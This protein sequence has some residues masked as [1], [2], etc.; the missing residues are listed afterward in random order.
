MKFKV[1]IPN[2]EFKVLKKDWTVSSETILVKIR[3]NFKVAI[4]VAAIFEVDNLSIFINSMNKKNFKKNFKKQIST[5]IA[6]QLR[7]MHCVH[8]LMCDHHTL[9]A[10]C[11]TH[12]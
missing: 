8:Q 4:V 1:C 9:S 6:T 2:N 5:L 7:K 12:R 3:L 10:M 11:D